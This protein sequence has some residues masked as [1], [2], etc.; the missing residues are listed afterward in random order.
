[1]LFLPTLDYVLQ[2]SP[3]P[4]S[5]SPWGHLPLWS[6]HPASHLTLHLFIHLD[7]CPLHPH[8]SQTCASLSFMLENWLLL[9]AFPKSQPRVLRCSCPVSP[10]TLCAPPRHLAHWGVRPTDMSVSFLRASM[11]S[12]SC[13]NTWFP[14]G[15]R[16][17]ECLGNILLVEN[18]KGSM[19]DLC[20][21]PSACRAELGPCAPS[22][23]LG[24]NQ[25]PLRLTLDVIPTSLMAW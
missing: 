4:R 16:H 9:A 17:R 8:S 11:G 19:D 5:L 15:A 6:L 3:T 13:H 22:G 23:A 24:T 10:S 7:P 2:G 20:T 14:A 25:S 21:P 12:H 1:M 18:L